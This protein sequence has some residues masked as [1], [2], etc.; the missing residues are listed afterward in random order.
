[1][2]ERSEVLVEL[3]V[4]DEVL[5]VELA[6]DPLEAA[7]QL[8]ELDGVLLLDGLHEEVGPD[9]LD[10]LAFALEEDGVVQGVDGDVDAALVLDDG[11]GAALPDEQLDREHDLLGEAHELDVG[12]ARPDLQALDLAEVE[13]LGQVHIGPLA[14]PEAVIDEQGV[15]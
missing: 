4:L 13:K 3:L 6:D 15:G 2:E 8:A 7:G 1:M 9:V 5:G 11:L 10:L 12:D 14:L